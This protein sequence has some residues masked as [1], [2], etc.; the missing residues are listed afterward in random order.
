MEVKK[1]VETFASDQVC[2][3]KTKT[4][5]SNKTCMVD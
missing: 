3:H 1:P 5:R 4:G 2:S